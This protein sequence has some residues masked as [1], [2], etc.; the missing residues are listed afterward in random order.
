LFFTDL[1]LTAPDLPFFMPGFIKAGTIRIFVIASEPL[2]VREPRPVIVTT[3]NAIVTS[4]GTMID[5]TKRKI[6]A[7][8]IVNRVAHNIRCPVHPQIVRSRGGTTTAMPGITGLSCRTSVG[9]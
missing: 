5:A 4:L 2:A 7:A 9:G 3:V 8:H 6:D 1:S